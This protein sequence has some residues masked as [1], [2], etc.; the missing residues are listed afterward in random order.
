EEEQNKLMYDRYNKCRDMELD[1]FWKNSVFVWVFLSLCFGAFGIVLMDYYAQEGAS[2]L[3]QNKAKIFLSA[4]SFIGFTMSKIWIWM[5]RGLK[6]WYEVY[7]NAVWDLESKSNVFKFD[8]QYT[9]ENYWNVKT[10]GLRP[11]NSD[12]ISPSRIVILIGRLMALSWS[13]SLIVWLWNLC[14]CTWFETYK[15]NWIFWGIILVCSIIIWICYASVKTTTLRDTDE[16]KIFRK[17]RTYLMN[18]VVAPQ[19]AESQSQDTNNT[20][21]KTQARKTLKDIYLSV[22]DGKIEF[23]F[24]NKDEKDLF[25]SVLD[26]YMEKEFDT[27]SD[28]KFKKIVK[29]ITGLFKKESNRDDILKYEN[30]KPKEAK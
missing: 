24:A 15:P 27:Y 1:R 2:K 5:A 9:I 13:S 14:G 29:K 19:Q 20:T 12:R 8:R 25:K 7:E 11:F 23:F 22:K 26:N 18:D 16:E 30:K 3:D 6:A 4:I 21:Q 28:G 17:I 10:N